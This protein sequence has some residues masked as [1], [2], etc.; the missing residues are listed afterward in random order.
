M[1]GNV[2]QIAVRI[3]GA[4]FRERAGRWPLRHRLLP[5]RKLLLD[6][7]EVFDLEAEMIDAARGRL[8]AIAQERQRQ[9]AVAHI[10]GA[11]ALS[12][13]DL[14]TENLL[15]ELRK[16]RGILCLDGKVT[17]FR[18]FS[19]R[20]AALIDPWNGTKWPQYSQTGVKCR[21]RCALLQLRIAGW[22][23]SP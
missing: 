14:E 5:F 8:A 11:A 16:P 7:P 1:R 19:S 9:I 4:I 15:I 6:L 18:H 12:M 17:D 22:S 2:E 13:N 23:D 3:H 21:Y 20:E 10:N